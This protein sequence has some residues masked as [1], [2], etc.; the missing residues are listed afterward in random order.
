MTPVA[1]S[2][3]LAERLRGSHWR[4][5]VTGA[6]GWLGQAALEILYQALG[7]TW[8]TR[9][10]SFGSS[11][12]SWSL[13]SGIQVRQQPLTRL[14]ELNLQPSLLL[15]FAYLT[16]EKT[17][18]M[19]TDEYIAINRSMSRLAAEGGAAVGVTRIFAL[20]S[21]AVHHALAAPDDPN[22]S[23]LYG[24][25][26]LEDEALFE[27]FALA[28]PERRVFLA[29]LFNL[30]GPYINKLDSYALAS[31]ITQARQGHIE[32]KAQRPVIRSYTSAENLLNVAFGQLLAKTSEP[33][34]CVETAGDHEIEMSE[35]AETVRSIVNPKALVTRM[36]LM[37]STSPD[38]YV[39]DGRRYRKLF[40][41]H[42]V[43]EHSLERQIADTAAYLE[44]RA[45]N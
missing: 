36:G 8:E 26:K 20:S 25:L 39:G 45:I 35:L 29:R 43:K 24:R 1:L 21:G 23:L 41:E 37:T 40:A 11:A 33:Y 2:P 22:S 15:H 4:I 10:M 28:A 14:P 3:E 34:V 16:R 31:F 17:G 30:S 38:H 19:A 5:L 12:R 13:R 42:G 44:Q 18:L 27:S 32:I 6:T 7:P 9:V